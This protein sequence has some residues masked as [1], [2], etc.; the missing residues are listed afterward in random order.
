MMPVS[1]FGVRET[2][3]SER[4]TTSEKMIR[5]KKLVLDSAGADASADEVLLHQVSNERWLLDPGLDWQI[6]K[7]EVIEQANGPPATEAVMRKPMHHLMHHP[8]AGTPMAH[9]FLPC[10]ACI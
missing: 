3:M 7:M 2:R 8:L 4:L 10:P 5:I 1:H 9:S 6:S